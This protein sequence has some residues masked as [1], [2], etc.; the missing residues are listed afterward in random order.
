MNKLLFLLSFVFTTFIAIAQTPSSNEVVTQGYAKMK[1]K[2]DLAFFRFTVTKRDTVERTT[3]GEL[4]SETD[5]LIRL[6]NSL[7]FQNKEMKVSDYDIS[8]SNTDYNYNYDNPKYYNARNTVSLRFRLNTKLV[9]AIYLLIEKEGMT[10]TEVSFET[11]LSD[12]LS[13]VT[14]AKLVQLALADAKEKAQNIASGLGL[15]LGKVKL[16]NNDNRMYALYDR[17]DYAFKN[18][19][20]ATY[21]FGLAAPTAYDKLDPEEKELDESISITFELTK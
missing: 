16:V 10:D 7:G 12:S 5:K 11:E 2:A 17:T 14:H 15:K 19:A 6:L 20:A 1:V 21:H 4:N 8:S 13:K 18:T 9:D 3:I